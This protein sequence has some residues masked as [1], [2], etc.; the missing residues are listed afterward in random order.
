[1]KTKNITIEEINE[2]R[3]ESRLRRDAYRWTRALE[4]IGE[5]FPRLAACRDAGQSWEE[6]ELSTREALE[7]AMEGRP[8]FLAGWPETDHDYA[9]IR[10]EYW[11]GYP[12]RW[13]EDES[14]VYSMDRA[15]VIEFARFMRRKGDRRIA[16]FDRKG[17]GPFAVPHS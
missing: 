14:P 11:G 12:G 5:P 9:K 10:A 2:A 1:M 4:R 3:A 17:R 15:S 8:L 6:L 13:I 16:L 7:S